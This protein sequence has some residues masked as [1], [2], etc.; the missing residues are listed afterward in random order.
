MNRTEM[1][2]FRLV[3]ICIWMVVATAGHAQDTTA[4]SPAPA[5]PEG[6]QLQ[7]RMQETVRAPALYQ[8][9]SSARQKAVFVASAG[10][11]RNPPAHPSFIFRVDPGTLAVQA[12]IPMDLKAYGLKLDDAADRLYVGHASEAAVTVLDTRS[13]Q[14]VGRVELVDRTT[15]AE[16]PRQPGG[17]YSIR[18]ITLDARHH[19]I[20]VM[21]QSWKLENTLHVVDTN[22]LKVTHRLEG[23][24]TIKVMGT[25]VDSQRQRLFASSLTPEFF[26]VDTEKMAIVSRTGLRSEQALSLL[27]QPTGN[28][29]LAVDHGG[30]IRYWQEKTVPGFRST[31][32][33]NEIVALDARTGE[34]IRHVPA[35]EGPLE[36]LL[37]EKRKRLFVTHHEAG[38]ISIYQSDTLELQHV[39]DVPPKP[40]SLAFDE[41]GNVLFVTV[42]RDPGKGVNPRTLPAVPERLVRIELPH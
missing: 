31:N 30:G 14:V 41:T 1:H 21:G 23:F 8:L 42:K 17:G 24:G 33:G 26:I 5:I 10:D 3:S 40:N 28:R 9:A 25:A 7:V 22:T 11:M 6:K 27:Y 2:K 19:R 29:V 16:A 15:M 39:I 4:P 38:K 37:D 34:E 13:N 32:P 35:A 36:M 12:R 18:Y 20:Y